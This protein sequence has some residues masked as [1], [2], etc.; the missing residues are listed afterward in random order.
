MARSLDEN[1]KSRSESRKQE[2]A[3]EKPRLD[4]ARRLRGIYF[5]VPN[6]EEYKEI[7]KNAR[8]KLERPMAPA[9][10]CDKPPKSI[11][12]V[13]AKPEIESEK[14]SKTASGCAVESH[15]STRQRVESSQP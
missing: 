3:K 8:R 2:W 15:E 1:W 13:T 6:D 12:K 10:P 14:N 5:I 7:L 4:N 9:T 11:T